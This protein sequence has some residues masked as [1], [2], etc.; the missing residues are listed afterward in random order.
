MSYTP[1]NPQVYYAAF[2]GAMAGFSTSITD[3]D[4]AS[5]SQ[6]ANA[7]AQEVDAIFGGQSYTQLQLSTIQEASFQ[8]WSGRS[9]L[10]SPENVTPSAYSQ[11]ATAVVD[12]ALAANSESQA[13]SGLS[14]ASWAVSQ[15]YI[16]PQNS[17]GMASD[18]NAGTT[19]AAP[20]KTW[21]GL[22]AKWGTNAPTLRQTT[23]VT[24]LSSHTDDS[25][26][27]LC[28][29]L[30]TNGASL[31]FTGTSTVLHSGTLSGVVAKNRA[32]PQ[33]W[34]VN[35]GVDPTPYVG[36]ALFHDKTTGA[37]CFI[38]RVVSG[39][40]CEL[41]QPLS[42]GGTAGGGFGVGAV[43]YLDTIADGDEYE[44]LSLQQINFNSL[45]CT[46]GV[47]NASF[48]NGIWLENCVGFDPGGFASASNLDIGYTL[49]AAQVIFQRTL[50]TPNGDNT[51][52]FDKYFENCW[53][54]GGVLGVSQLHMVG[55][56]ID[57]FG[58]FGIWGTASHLDGDCIL[59]S[60]L[61]GGHM[62]G[63][64]YQ[65]GRCYVD[66]GITLLVVGGYDTT[67]FS[68]APSG[69]TCIL[70]G[71]GSVDFALGA[72]YCHNPADTYTNSFLLKGSLA[73]GGATTCSAYSQ[74]AGTWYGG[75]ALSAA[76]LD[77]TPVGAGK[78][79]G[80]AINPL[81]GSV[82]TNSLYPSDI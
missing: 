22:V 18:A 7:F 48:N 4:Y 21:A 31:V 56:Q 41:T 46:V 70:W 52:S 19:Q 23:T 82:L 54:A 65:I 43:N 39:D 58:N 62:R 53:F 59:G 71:P 32:T 25:D 17:T 6:W 80:T 79:G 3:T 5:Q 69:A 38:R 14:P 72:T 51:V 29:P 37:Y 81:T 30:L 24:F 49:Q 35:L 1:N 9:P 57:S 50:S 47:F 15:W 61:E 8:V 73:L 64:F 2:A 78:F 44:I 12:M 77:A 74:A 10:P 34:Q 67:T 45:L 63:A 33:L 11:P 76:N 60:S 20:L 75:I 16:D 13:A 28:N 26:P 68:P 36:V 55:G 66:T 27:V 42:L 40:L